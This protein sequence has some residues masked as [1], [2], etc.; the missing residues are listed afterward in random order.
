MLSVVCGIFIF[1]FTD[2]SQTI[3][4]LQ[5]FPIEMNNT[6]KPMDKSPHSLAAS[7]GFALPLFPLPLENYP[8]RIYS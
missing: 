2:G 4:M 3:I 1:F 8:K 5:P 6:I 7:S